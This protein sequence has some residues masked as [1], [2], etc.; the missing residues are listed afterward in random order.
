MINNR[1]TDSLKN[2][3][4]RKSFMKHIENPPC[5]PNE[6][7]LS[8][9]KQI[10]ENIIGFCNII[11]SLTLDTMLNGIKNMYE[12]L[13]YPIRPPIE[14]AIA[15]LRLLMCDQFS[16]NDKEFFY[17]VMGFAFLRN[18]AIC[19]DLLSFP[20]IESF[21]HVYLDPSSKKAISCLKVFVGSSP[22][23]VKTLLE[24]GYIHSLEIDLESASVETSVSILEILKEITRTGDLDDSFYID[25]ISPLRFGMNSENNDVFTLSL[26]ILELI[27]E[28][29]QSNQVFDFV[30]N[31]G[32]Y[33]YLLHSY[34][35]LRQYDR[36]QVLK[37]FVN[38]TGGLRIYSER[39]VNN[40]I[41]EELHSL[42]QISNEKC[43]SKIINVFTNL[44][45]LGGI[46]IQKLH[47][48]GFYEFAFDILNN[49]SLKA[50]MSSLRFFCGNLFFFREDIVHNFLIQ[51]HVISVINEVFSI[52][53]PKYFNDVLLSIK[54]VFESIMNESEENPFEHDLFYNFDLALFEQ[55]LQIV[56]NSNEKKAY[57]VA[58]YFIDIIEAL[59]AQSDDDEIGYLINL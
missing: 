45:E 54:I 13:K 34:N 36:E 44:L 31:E 23:M 21:L 18:P 4:I 16:I 6:I 51:N 19:I 40:N 30:F 58:N 42:I 10:V 55:T 7:S 14:S 57:K 5:I 46:V 8:E 41:I 59:L 24:I 48:L 52:A 47:S 17:E 22:L 32:I 37:V 11:P 56:S 28:S 53:R 39:L 49:G 43:F 33:D 15:L 35:S 26:S 38:I 1:D 2:E 9:S 29:T 50:K 20:E 25:L 12:L 3:M 27:L